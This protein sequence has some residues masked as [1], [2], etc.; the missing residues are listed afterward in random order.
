MFHINR[1]SSTPLHVQLEEQIHFGI[2]SGQLAPGTRLPP[3]RALAGQLSLNTNTVVRVYRDLQSSGYLV[4]ERGAG[5]SVAPR[6]P[7]PPLDRAD[8]KKIRCKTKRLVRLCQDAGMT[9]GELTQLT[10]GVWRE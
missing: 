2:H 10:E 8:L 6:P 5:T 7:G 3:V 4:M 1:A 9:L